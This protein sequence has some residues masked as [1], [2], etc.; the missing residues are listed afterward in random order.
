MQDDQNEDIYG[1][2]MLDGVFDALVLMYG[3]E[4][5][6]KIKNIERFKREIKVLL[7]TFFFFFFVFFVFVFICVLFFIKKHYYSVFVN[8]DFLC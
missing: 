8:I 4:D 6:I 7:Q 1:R 2:Q 3:L 5:L